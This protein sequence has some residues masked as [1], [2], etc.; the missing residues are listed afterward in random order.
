MRSQK[1]PFRNHKR[2]TDL[3]CCLKHFATSS[4]KYLINL[5]GRNVDN[6]NVGN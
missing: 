6:N 4:F 2:N 5:M 3:N 1:V